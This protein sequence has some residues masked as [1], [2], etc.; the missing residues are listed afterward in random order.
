MGTPRHVRFG[1]TVYVHPFSHGGYLPVSGP[2]EAVPADGLLAA[3]RELGLDHLQFY[4]DARYLDEELGDLLPWLA[5]HGIPFHLNVETM[6]NA[7][8]AGATKTGKNNGAYHLFAGWLNLGKRGEVIAQKGDEFEMATR[9]AGGIY[10]P[11]DL[12][13]WNDWTVIG[14]DR[15]AFWTANAEAIAIPTGLKEQTFPE[16]PIVAIAW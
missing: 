6:D 5:E 11:L 4:P 7:I 13:P 10:L 16:I 9:F 8:F 1:A 15:H 3:Y 12:E 14:P 2:E